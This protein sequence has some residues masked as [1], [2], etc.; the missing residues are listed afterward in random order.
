MKDKDRFTFKN[1]GLRS[2]VTVNGLEKAAQRA[3]F[4]S[5]GINNKDLSR[6]FI[7]V[8]NSWNEI[9]PGCKHLKGIGEAVKNGVWKTGGVPFEFN[10]IAV[11]DGIAQGHVGM[12]YPLVSREIIAASIE[13]MLESHRFDGAVFIS[14]CDKV[15]PGML[16]AAARVNI[17]SIFVCA[18][19]MEAGEFNQEP[20]TISKMREYSGKYLAGEITDDELVEIEEIAC[21]SLG[22]CSMLG[23]ANTMASACE[24]MGLTLPYSATAPA[25]GAA[26]QR[27][28]ILAGERIMS[29]VEVGLRPS[30]II[31]KNSLINA[32]RVIMAIGGSSNSLIHI[33]AVASEFD[34]NLDLEEIEQATKSVPS[35]VKVNPSSKF[36][37]GVL[38]KAG[39]IPAV[40]KSL[41]SILNFDYLAVSG[42]RISKQVDMAA[43][44]DKDFIRPMENP[45]DKEGSLMILKGNLAPLGAVVKASAVEKHMWVFSGKAKVYEDLSD[46]IKAVKESQI[47]PGTVIVIRYEGPKG[48]P[49]MREMQTITSLIAGSGL[50]KQVALVTDGRFS[51]STRGPCIGHIAP[52]AADG[53]LI[54]IIRDGD[55]IT[56]D[57]YK[58]QLHVDLSDE[59]IKERFKGWNPLVKK[60]KGILNLFS[61]L[62]GSVN[63][64]V[65]WKY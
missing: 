54:A 45:F 58:R 53:G 13:I 65:T 47:S 39:G 64:G 16:M 15:T 41:K 35:I 5:L 31:T 36:P 40:M 26:K 10:T 62:C 59:T 27:E 56:I 23:T 55:L 44:I 37:I 43:W 28:A 9:V 3:L 25:T 38:H 30:E 12:K 8:V 48:G 2:S 21:P 50:N 18:G 32:L 49:G 33:P 20:I 17:P 46:A 52:E 14:S 34:I 57:L 19:T 1:E 11:C 51:G 4:N 7:A 61:K 22:T 63:T 29:L 24:V 60:S 42:D 6:P